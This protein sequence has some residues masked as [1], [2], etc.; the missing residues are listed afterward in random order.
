MERNKNY[1]F[2]AHRFI[3]INE[4]SAQRRD[5]SPTHIRTRE[6]PPTKNRRF[7]ISWKISNAFDNLQK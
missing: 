3:I 7:F 1:R 2:T 4:T 6:E 5:V